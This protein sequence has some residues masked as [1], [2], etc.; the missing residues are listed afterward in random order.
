MAEFQEKID[1]LVN[2]VAHWEQELQALREIVAETRQ[3]REELR[4][5]G[6]GDLIF[7]QILDT[8]KSF[9]EAE[10]SCVEKVGEFLNDVS[11][12]RD[13]L[14]KFRDVMQA[15]YDDYVELRQSIPTNT[16]FQELQKLEADLQNRLKSF[17]EEVQAAS[18]NWE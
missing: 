6:L 15:S 4:K 14:A 8:A 17:Q 13:R 7:A 10:E 1:A 9:D 11:N 2:E 12:F 18:E 16:K 5:G 3:V